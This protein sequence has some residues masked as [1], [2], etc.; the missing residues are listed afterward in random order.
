MMKLLKNI[1]LV[2]LLLALMP[3]C[4]DRF[5]DLEP[6]GSYTEAVYFKTP[7]HFEYASNQLYFNL[8]GWSRVKGSGLADAYYTGYGDWMDFGSDLIALPQAEGRGTNTVEQTN[9]YWTNHYYFLRDVNTLIAKSEEFTGDMA[10][11][12]RYVATAYFFRAYHYYELLQNFGGVPII[13]EN[14]ELDDAELKLAKRNSRYEVVAQVLADLDVAIAGLPIEQEIPDSDKGKVSKWAA[15]SLKARVLLYEATWEKYVGTS[16]DGDGETVGAG[17]FVPDQYPSVSDMLSEAI[18]LSADVIN[19]GGYELW[20]HNDVLDNMSNYYLFNL[21]GDAS[22][23]LGLGKSSN[24]EFIIQG[25]YDFILRQAG[26][27]AQI[28]HTVAGR[29]APSRKMLDLF[30]CT[31]GLPIDKSALFQGYNKMSD[32]IKNRDYRMKSYFSDI[33]ADGSPA[34][35]AQSE[36]ASGVGVTNQKFE[37]YDYPNYRQTTQE[38]QNFPYLRLAEVYL[39]YAEALFERDGAISDADLNLSINLT[40]GRAGLDPLSNSL[41]NDNGLDML[42][43]IRRERTLEL[44]GEN[45]RFNDLKRWGIAEAELSAA[46]HGPIIE[47]TIYETDA[48]LYKPEFFPFGLEKVENGTGTLL[49]AVILDATSN[50]NFTR[51]NY[52]SPI[53]LADILITEELLQNPGW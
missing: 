53:P 48:S 10:D 43:E 3:S 52:L 13:T 7:E 35:T 21:D 26:A 33:P 30:L 45:S 29:L 36:T 50:R 49:N 34:L 11:I 37:S 28:S 14:F 25:I 6:R 18:T 42:E 40:R 9:P 12:N 8:I 32:E 51:K 4:Q 22:N 38:S 27:S 19:N 39:I 5:I 15:E 16:T 20:N 24:N 46:V 31:D 23:P 2:A 17:S 44:F 1:T 41:V 47:G